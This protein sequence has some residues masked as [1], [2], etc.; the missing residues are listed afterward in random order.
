MQK[1]H[2]TR[3][4]RQKRRENYACAFNNFAIGRASSSRLWRSRFWWDT[5]WM[6]SSRFWRAAPETHEEQRG[7]LHGNGRRPE[8]IEIRRREPVEAAGSYRPV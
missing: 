1:T 3:L 8:S 5:P 7:F 6:C 4:K 2:K